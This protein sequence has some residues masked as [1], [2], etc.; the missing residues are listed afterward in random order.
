MLNIADPCREV[1]EAAWDGPKAAEVTTS[2]A[3]LFFFF[4]FLFL[5]FFLLFNFITITT[6][7]IVVTIINIMRI[8]LRIIENV[9]STF[10]ILCR[11]MI[12]KMISI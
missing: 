12:S 8:L 2:E 7:T 1:C 5:F 3:T 10:V 4:V 9:F 6:T 11:S